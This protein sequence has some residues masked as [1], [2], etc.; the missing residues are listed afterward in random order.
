MP[1]PGKKKASEQLAEPT[2][3]KKK[4]KTRPDQALFGPR[5]RGENP[6]ATPW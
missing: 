3:R 1:V 5:P 2:F 6:S 4:K